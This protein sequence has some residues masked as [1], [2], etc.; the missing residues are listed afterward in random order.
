[1]GSLSQGLMYYFYT[2]YD[3]IAFLI[4]FFSSLLGVFIWH[5]FITLFL[6]TNDKHNLLSSNEEEEEDT[7]IFIH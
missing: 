6:T 3:A 5:W 4:G 1:M 2:S 7:L